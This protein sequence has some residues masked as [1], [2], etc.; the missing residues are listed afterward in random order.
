MSHGSGGGGGGGH[1]H[2]HASDKGG[3]HGHGGGEKK[4]VAK[5]PPPPPLNYATLKK[6]VK[7]STEKLDK[8]LLAIPPLVELESHTKI[9]RRKLLLF[10]ISS[11]IFLI[12]VIT[13]TAGNF[14]T[15]ALGYFYPAYESLRAANSG[16]DVE[17]QQWISYWVI[18]GTLTLV[19][20]SDQALLHMLPYYFFF[21]SIFIMWLVLPQYKGSLRVYNNILKHA[22]QPPKK[23][24][25][26]EGDKKGGGSSSGGKSGGGGGGKEG[27]KK[28]PPKTGW[29]YAP[30]SRV[31]R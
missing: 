1:G 2:G 17:C 11:L 12:L 15:H 7:E 22:I 30:L 4:E 31:V 16:K 18:L 21:K 25:E 14:L 19:E 9:H 8:A 29:G 24:A 28:A 13:N 20:Y 5:K 27:D 3:G 26:G 10:I 6:T 23:K